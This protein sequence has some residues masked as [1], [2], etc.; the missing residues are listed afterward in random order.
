M[1]YLMKRLF[2]LASAGGIVARR[3]ASIHQS[4]SMKIIFPKDSEK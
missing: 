4:S 1:P 3:R 2:W